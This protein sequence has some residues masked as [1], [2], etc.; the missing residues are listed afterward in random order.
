MELV[1]KSSNAL[2]IVDMDH[3]FSGHAI[4]QNP[5]VIDTREKCCLHAYFFDYNQKQR[6]LDCLTKEVFPKSKS[7]RIEL[8]NKLSFYWMKITELAAE[9][10]KARLFRGKYKI[11]G[12]VNTYN[13]WIPVNDF[14]AMEADFVDDLIPKESVEDFLKFK[15]KYSTLL[16]NI[17][18]NDH[19]I[20]EI[21]CG[22]IHQYGP[23]KIKP[24]KINKMFQAA[25][26]KFISS[27]KHSK[28]SK[29]MLKNL[30]ESA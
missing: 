20:E 11:K 24:Y 10:T 4:S 7:K 2:G 15:T 25:S 22:F 29:R 5:R 17:G 13:N 30:F 19:A 14:I 9:R 18:I 27:T 26:V 1:S 3:D 28:Q 16:D 8:N 12:T 6:F 23:Q 21:I